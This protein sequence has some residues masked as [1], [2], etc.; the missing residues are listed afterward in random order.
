ME[1]LALG[2]FLSI[3]V[4]VGAGCR[5]EGTDSYGL[6]FPGSVTAGLQLRSANGLEALV[7]G[8]KAGGREKRG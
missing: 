5:E 2:L 6:D 1:A 3:E 7:G 4:G 8:R